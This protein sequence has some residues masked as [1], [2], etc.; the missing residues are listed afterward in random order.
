MEKDVKIFFQV[1]YLPYFAPVAFYLFLKVKLE[2]ASGL[3]TQGT[4]KKVLQ[5][6]APT[7]ATEELASAILG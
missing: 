7:V 6:V 3:L 2:L 1:Y 5:G 4:I